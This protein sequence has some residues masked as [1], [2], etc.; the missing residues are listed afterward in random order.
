MGFKLSPVTHAC[1]HSV[2]C[3]LRRSSPN[4]LQVVLA[5]GS[6]DRDRQLHDDIA[7]INV[8]T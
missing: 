4:V 8:A 1:C 2:P 5:V 7:G 6:L 3:I